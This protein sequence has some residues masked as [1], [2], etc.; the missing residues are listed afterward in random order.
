MNHPC[1]VR[2]MRT[3]QSLELPRCA[4]PRPGDRVVWYQDAISL[5]GTLLGHNANGQPCIKLTSWCD[6]DTAVPNSFEAIRIEDPTSVVGPNWTNLPEGA[7]VANPT[8]S[9]L[10]EL[11]RLLDQQVPP[12]P[13]HI[14]LLAEIWCRGFEVFVIGGTV[15][16]V[17]SQR[18]AKDVDISTT[19]PLNRLHDLLLSM[20]RGPRRLDEAAKRNGHLRL[21]GSPRSV[22]PFLDLS[23]FKY[24]FPGAPNVMFGNSFERDVAHRDFSCNSVYYDPQ[25][26][27]LIDPTGTGLTDAHNKLLR[28]AYDRDCRA[29]YHLAQAV[30]RM[31]KLFVRGFHVAPEGIEPLRVAMK[32]LAAMTH[33]TRI[34]Y[35]RRQVIDGNP[36]SSP[37]F[38]Y[39]QMRAACVALGGE[40]EWTLYVDQ[41]R[42]EILS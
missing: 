4:L 25:N 19:M 12:G 11:T 32:A 23:V 13:R 38:C 9:E 1:P 17:I 21:G 10:A 37:Q 6:G 36:Q 16:D 5:K 24:Q 42:E 35:I 8:E 41:Y 39:E 40:V 27:V 15:R 34:K 29:D 28:V 7:I 3:V 18:P 33:E 14:D 31:C 30:I 22:D 2:A 20:Y 26:R